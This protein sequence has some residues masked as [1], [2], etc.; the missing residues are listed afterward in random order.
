MPIRLLTC[1][2]L[3]A[4]LTPSLAHADSGE[5]TLSAHIDNEFALLHHPY[6]DADTP[7]P[8][9]HLYVPRFGGSVTYGLHNR[10]LV[11]L[12]GHASLPRSG[13]VPV[14]QYSIFD[15]APHNEFFI[16]TRD[17]LATALTR[18][19]VFDG[20]YMFVDVGLE[21]GLSL[22]RW[23]ASLNRSDRDEARPL[24]D[25]SST[26]P[27]R[28]I[29]KHAPYLRASATL[30]ARPWQYLTIALSPYVATTFANDLSVGAA[31]DIGVPLGAGPG[32]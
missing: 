29:W 2:G 30:R 5:V 20:N 28:V 7:A 32:F 11:G 19:T 22:R 6:H 24:A 12:S 3:L 1:L 10:L 23:R 25:Y 15:P 8:A 18:F 17:I 16:R 26:K 27:S 31:F 13:W 9:L 14:L 21:G 4:L